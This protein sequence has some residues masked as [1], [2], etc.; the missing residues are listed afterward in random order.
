MHSYC[1]LTVQKVRCVSAYLLAKG[2]VLPGQSLSGWSAT[3]MG[4]DGVH[5]LLGMVVDALEVSSVKALWGRDEVSGR[6]G[7][8][9]NKGYVAHG[10]GYSWDGPC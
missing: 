3:V 4:F 5:D 6:I 8:P 2:L 10:D 7:S 9:T 1:V